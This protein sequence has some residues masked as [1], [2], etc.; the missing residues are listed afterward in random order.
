MVALV[1]SRQDFPNVNFI[2]KRNFSEFWLSC[3]SKLVTYEFSKNF[4]CL[5]I[6]FRGWDSYHSLCENCRETANAT[7]K[8]WKYVF[9]KNLQPNFEC[10]AHLYYGEGGLHHSAFRSKNGSMSWSCRFAVRMR[11]IC[12]LQQ[13]LTPHGAIRYIISS[14]DMVPVW[15][16]EM[17]RVVQLW[18]LRSFSK[19]YKNSC[20]SPHHSSTGMYFRFSSSIRCIFYHTPSSL[21]S[22]LLATG[23]WWEM[24]L[25]ADPN[26][27]ILAEKSPNNIYV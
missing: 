3:G 10:A 2:G 5:R 23:F 8:M 24:H 6:F 27:M 21:G 9:T 20:R 17:L 13:N 11:F 12:M 18:L 19:S 7:I 16:R 22:L 15:F 1:V 4:N 14:P 26:P 25:I